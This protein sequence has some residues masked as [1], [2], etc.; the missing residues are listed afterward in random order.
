MKAK[1]KAALRAVA[2]ALASKQARGPEMALAR[3]ILAAL[4][5]KLGINFAEYAK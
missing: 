2:R 3:I 5:V 1:A 4:G